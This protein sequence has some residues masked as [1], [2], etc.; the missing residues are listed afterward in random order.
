MKVV[1]YYRVSTSAQGRSGLG[2]DDGAG[3]HEFRWRPIFPGKFR[4]AAELYS[5]Y[6]CRAHAANAV[7]WRVEIAHF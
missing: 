1:A 3:K 2:L 5:E 7:R 4:K 6:S